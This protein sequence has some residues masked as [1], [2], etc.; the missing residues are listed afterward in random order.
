MPLLGLARCPGDQ[1]GVVLGLPRREGIEHAGRGIAAARVGVNDHVAVRHPVLRIRR[2]PA[3]EAA[4]RGLAEFRVP[5]DKLVPGVLV[6]GRVGVPGVL[7][8]GPV[9]HHD[10]KAAGLV[11]AVD[12]GPQRQSIA[13]GHF[14]IALE[15]HPGHAGLH[16]LRKARFG[17]GENQSGCQKVGEVQI[18]AYHCGLL[19]AHPIA[20]M[21]GICRFP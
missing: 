15:D 18:S 12:I 11:G 20:G 3:D 2:F 9:Q 8:V 5:G 6:G 21:A 17:H 13:H 19:L 10:R 4:G 1:R 16:V 14:H 7:A